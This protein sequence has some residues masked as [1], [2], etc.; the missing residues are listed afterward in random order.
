MGD[1]TAILVVRII[2]IVDL[3]VRLLQKLMVDNSGEENFKIRKTTVTTKTTTKTT[4]L[5]AAAEEEEEEAVSDILR[6]QMNNHK[7]LHHLPR[8]VRR[9]S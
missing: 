5:V 6:E 7:D 9:S 3:V 2:T 4:M 8:S 1:T